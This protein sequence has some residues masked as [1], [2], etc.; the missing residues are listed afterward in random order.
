MTQESHPFFQVT[1]RGQATTLDR[2]AIRYYFTRESG[3]AETALCYWVTGDRCSLAKM[4]FHDLP[5]PMANA[6][7]YLEVTFP[8]ASNVTVAAGTLEVRVGFRTGSD[9]LLQSNDYS[10]DANATASSST[11]PFPYKRWPQATLYLNGALVWGNE[12]CM[13]S[14]EKR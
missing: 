2:L 3:V 5:M 12:P 14:G 13:A 9:A 8:N 4:E 11:M 7:R 6:S 10:F 1:N